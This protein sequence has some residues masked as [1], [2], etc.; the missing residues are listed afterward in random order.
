MYPVAHLVVLWNTWRRSRTR[1]DYFDRD[2]RVRRRRSGGR[3][4]A[5]P[6]GAFRAIRHEVGR[7]AFSTAWEDRP[8]RKPPRYTTS[9]IVDRSTGPTDIVRT[10]LIPLVAPMV[11]TP[12]SATMAMTAIGR[13]LFATSLSAR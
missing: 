10:Y 6:F 4:L 11:V 8:F 2:R 13:T 12:G 7:T 5:Q 3:T 9:A 1:R